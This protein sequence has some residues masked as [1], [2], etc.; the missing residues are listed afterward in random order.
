MGKILST[1]G[2]SVDLSFITA[3]SAD[4]LDGYINTNINAELIA[5]SITNREAISQSLNASGEYTI[6]AGYH[7][8]SGKITANTLASQTSADATAGNILDTITAWVNGSQVTGNMTNQGAKTSSLNAGGSYTIPAGYHNGSGIISANTL[9]S[10]TAGTASAAHILSGKTAWVGG[11]QLTGTLAVQNI[12]S[13]T[14]TMQSSSVIRISWKNPAK[15]PYTGVKI[16]MSTSGNPGTSGTAK[17][18]GTGSSTT[19]SGTSYVDITGLSAATKY[20]FTVCAYVTNV[21]NGTSFNVNATTKAAAGSKTFTSSGTF[22]VPAGVTS[23][24]IF[25]VGGGGSS[26]YVYGSS[27]NKCYAGGGG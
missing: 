20:Y 24:D 8:G 5:G 23:I 18:T 26:G 1:M 15:G 9:A 2:G 7:D 16:F 14:A 12:S 10:Q 22:T 3:T 17:Y 11:S 27:S 4:I 19:A 21:G 25:C 6:P 13:V